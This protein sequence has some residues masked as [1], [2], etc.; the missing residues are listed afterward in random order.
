MQS[1]NLVMFGFVLPTVYASGSGSVITYSLVILKPYTSS[2][3][4]LFMLQ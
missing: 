2:T 3:I 4:A 1:P